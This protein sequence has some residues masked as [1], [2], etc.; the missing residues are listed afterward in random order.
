MIKSFLRG[1]QRDWDKNLGSLNGAYQ[2]TVHES[3]GMTPN[4]LMFGSEHR[5]PI[6]V[7]LGT[8]K[9]PLGEEVTSYGEY[10]D[11]LRDCIQRA[12]DI[13]RK[14]LGRNAV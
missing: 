2:D 6:E 3:T 10:V 12:H 14:Y 11:G 4:L 8:G 5:L 1:K 9:L 13:A 7:I